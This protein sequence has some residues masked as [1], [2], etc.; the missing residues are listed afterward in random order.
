MTLVT[1]TGYTSH[2]EIVWESLVDVNGAAAEMFSGDFRTVSH[3]SGGQQVGRNDNAGGIGQWEDA[4]RRYREGQQSG[5]V[6]ASGRESEIAPPLP[7]PRPTENAA[8]ISST[9]QADHDFA[10]AL[11]LQEEEEDAQ[12]Q[13]E[14]RRRRE[15]ELSERFLSNHETPPAIPPRRG[16]GRRQSGATAAPRQN[17]IPPVSRPGGDGAGEA[18]P[19]SY[20]QSRTDR[21]LRPGERP[22]QPSSVNAGPPQAGRSD[23]IGAGGNQPI[24]AGRGRGGPVRGGRGGGRGGGVGGA[25]NIKDAEDK[26]VVM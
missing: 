26:C 17:A 22:P 20:E 16:S 25:A 24:P 13:A 14:E 6:D 5:V 23:W 4:Q 7:G 8:A 3:G 21:V 15:Q 12:R 19:P 18:P 1:D 2:E 11:Q 9:E 10:L